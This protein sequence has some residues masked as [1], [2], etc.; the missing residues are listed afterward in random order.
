[1]PL[2]LRGCAACFT[3]RSG[4]PVEGTLLRGPAS[5]TEERGRR[6]EM[7]SR[8]GVGEQKFS[9]LIFKGPELPVSSEGCEDS[10]APPPPAEEAGL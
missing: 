1:M 8:S 9:I 7:S 3:Y 10:Q 4:Y 2:R 6:H 5:P